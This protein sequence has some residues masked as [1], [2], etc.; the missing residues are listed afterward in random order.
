MRVVHEAGAGRHHAW[1]TIERI[2]PLWTGVVDNC[3][4][5]DL[6]G[7]RSDAYENTCGQFSYTLRN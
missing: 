4:G 6:D 1:S 5:V 3:G 2:W 7:P